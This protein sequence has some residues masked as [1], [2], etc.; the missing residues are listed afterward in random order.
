MPVADRH[1]LAVQPAELGPPGA[2]IDGPRREDLA[3]HRERRRRQ[4][5]GERPGERRRAE[6]HQVGVARR[7]EHRLDLVDEL[8]AVEQRPGRGVVGLRRELQPVVVA[9]AAA[10]RSSA[11]SSGSP[12][13]ARQ[14]A[15]KAFASGEILRKKKRSRVRT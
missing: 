13:R 8:V 7:G 12:A 11:P 3:E 4:P 1:V 5:G 10:G 2:E 14:A 9:A 6:Q 15:R